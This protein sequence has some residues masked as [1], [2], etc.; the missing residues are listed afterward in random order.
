MPL[1]QGSVIGDIHIVCISHGWLVTELKYGSLLEV[2][3]IASTIKAIG[4]CAQKC[5]PG[6]EE[7]GWMGT[8]II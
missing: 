3:G 1:A 4:I 2:G 7:Q 8:V 5:N 6:K